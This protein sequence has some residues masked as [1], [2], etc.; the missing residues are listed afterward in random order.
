M[1]AIVLI[2]VDLPAPLSPTSAITSP[3]NARKSTLVSACTGPKLFETSR[4]SSVGVSVLFMGERCGGRRGTP[5]GLLLLA[6]LR[7]HAGADVAPLQIPVLDRDVPVLLRDRN[8]SREDGGNLTR[9]VA[10]LAVDANGLAALEQRDRE[11]RGGVRLDA[12]GLVDR[13]ALPA[14]EDV[15]DP[16]R[17]GVLARHRD[18]LQVACLQ[19]RDDGITEAVVRGVDAVD[20]VARLLQHLL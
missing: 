18:L 12:H 17:G 6:E 2:S 13:H 20:L 11:G 4:S 16:L 9:P 15:L 19:R 14:G 8:R 1:P 5:H 3:A 7:V 10:D